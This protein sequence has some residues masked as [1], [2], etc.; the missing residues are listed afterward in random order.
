MMLCFF[1]FV[2]KQF[3]YGCIIPFSFVSFC[4][5]VWV[6]RHG[7]MT[8]SPWQPSFVW[9]NIARTTLRCLH[10]QCLNTWYMYMPYLTHSPLM[11][12]ITTKLNFLSHFK[13]DGNVIYKWAPEL[14]YHQPKT[15]RYFIPKC[16]WN[17]HCFWQECFR[18]EWVNILVSHHLVFLRTNDITDDGE[19]CMTSDVWF[20]FLSHNAY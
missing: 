18:G 4:R 10:F 6:H 9:S 5:E 15:L 20:E 17:C 3:T 8:S 7:N 12:R 2:M 1:F 13:V 11:T 14:I 16:F 19:R